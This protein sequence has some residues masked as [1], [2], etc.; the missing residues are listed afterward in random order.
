MK[1]KAFVYTLSVTCS[2]IFGLTFLAVKIALTELDTLQLLAC[3]WTISL[4]LFAVLIMMKVVKVS[5]KGKPI[6]LVLLLA[7]I[8]PCCNTILETIGIDLT[9]A[10]ESSILYALSPISVL[11]LSAIFMGQKITGRAV[12]GIMVSFVG[13]VISTVFAEGFSVGGKL[14]GYMFMIGA[15][16]T[17]AVFSILSAKIS[18]RF[19]P[20]ERT[21]TM[22]LAGSI[23]FNM[24]NLG[25]GAGFEGF[26]ICF[27]DS[28]VGLA[29]LFLGAGGSFLAYFLLNY[30]LSKLPPAQVTTLNINIMTVTGV[31]SGIIVQGDP[32]GWYT[33]V[34]MIMIVIGVVTANLQPKAASIE[35]IK[36]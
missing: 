7:L 23:W 34:G 31:V 22:A 6:K 18:D 24:I 27:K 3:R 5:F 19:T 29:V 11:I 16:L 8:Q 2:I 30:V 4:M 10:S 32:F 28:Q 36:N 9:T 12:T 25:R 17:G 33:V 15:V 1:S 13:V 14:T 20:T 21:F 35:E 26:V